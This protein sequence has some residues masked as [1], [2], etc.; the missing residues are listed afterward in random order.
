MYVRH[1]ALVYC[2]TSAKTDAFKSAGCQLQL[3]GET[4]WVSL[5]LSARII[6]MHDV[7]TGVS[8]VGRETASPIAH[9]TGY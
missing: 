3:S 6:A 5:L 7:L 8:H 4:W 2:A 9:N 1:V